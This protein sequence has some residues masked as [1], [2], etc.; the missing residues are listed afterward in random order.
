MRD[1]EHRRGERRLLWDA[2]MLDLAWMA[3]WCA[4]SSRMG[5]FAAFMLRCLVVSVVFGL[6]LA[7]GF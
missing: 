1:E 3:L 4:R 2:A 7:F 5:F 6:G